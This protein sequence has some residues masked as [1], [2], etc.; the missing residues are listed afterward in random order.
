MVLRIKDVSKSK[1]VSITK[2]A[3]LVEITQ[4]NMSNIANGKTS[5][6]LELLE[7]IASALEVE[8][9]ELFAKRGDFVAFVRRNGEIHTFDT[10]KDLIAYTEAL[11]AQ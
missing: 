7:R 1:G 6:S 10:E 4:P 11:K 5:P 9:T 3:E 2:L 8:V